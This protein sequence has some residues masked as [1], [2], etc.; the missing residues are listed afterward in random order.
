MPPP[1]PVAPSAGVKVK[2]EREG[3]A[4]T[5]ARKAA[6]ARVLAATSPATVIDL[7]VID[8]CD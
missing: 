6:R 8:L 3:R 5:D 7:N 4:E 2:R 1:V